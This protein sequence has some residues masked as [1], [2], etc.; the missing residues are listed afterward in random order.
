MS[1]FTVQ[2]RV[3]EPQS[4]FTVR[5]EEVIEQSDNT[6]ERGGAGGG[7]SD[8]NCSPTNMGQRRCHNRVKVNGLYDFGRST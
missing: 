1:T 7:P 6:G 5:N 3:K 8:K 2:P 4:G